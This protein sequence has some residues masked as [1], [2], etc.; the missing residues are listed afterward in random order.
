MRRFSPPCPHASPS[1][2]DRLDAVAL[3]PALEG[4]AAAAG[5]APKRIRDG[6]HALSIRAAPAD[7][8]VRFTL[9]IALLQ[10]ERR[11][12]ASTSASSARRLGRTTHN[13]SSPSRS[14][15]AR[16]GAIAMSKSWL[17]IR[18]PAASRRGGAKQAQ[19]HSA[20]R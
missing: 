4:A 14:A 6:D 12:A 9:L 16:R 15:G 18:V 11:R 8:M 17:T 1:R 20:V 13:E 5:I 7:V 3:H 19:I 2:C 10:L